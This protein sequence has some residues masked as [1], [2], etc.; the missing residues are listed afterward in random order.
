MLGWALLTMV[1]VLA[2]FATLGLW[3]LLGVLCSAVSERLQR[4]RTV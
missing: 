2:V 3:V 1:Y 4:S